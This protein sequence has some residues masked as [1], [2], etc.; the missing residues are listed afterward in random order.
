VLQ[1]PGWKRAGF[2]LRVRQLAQIHREIDAWT[3]KADYLNFGIATGPE[4]RRVLNNYVL[5]HDF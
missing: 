1:R 3:G 2:Q 4:N 5:A